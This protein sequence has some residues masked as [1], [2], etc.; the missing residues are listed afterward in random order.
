[1]TPGATAARVPTRSESPSAEPTALLESPPDIPRAWRDGYV[2]RRILVRRLSDARHASVAAIVAPPG[3]GKSSLISE[4][5]RHD[6][7]PFIWPAM[8]GLAATD[9]N[10]AASAILTTLEQAGWSDGLAGSRG[11]HSP[12]RDPMGGLLAA[13]RTLRAR[14]QAF[15]LVL[16]DAHRLAHAVL[17]ELARVMVHEAPSGATLALASRSEL[18]IPLGRLRASRTL[19][20]VRTPELA[21]IPRDALVLLR[22]AGLELEVGAVRKLV[23]L[24]EGWPVGLYL[25]A[26]WVNEQEDPSGAVQLLRGDHHLFDEYFRDEVLSTLSDEMREFATRTSVLKEL[27]GPICDEVLG[28]RGSGLTLRALERATPLLRP[29]DPAHERCRWHSMLRDVLQAELRR[30]EPELVQTLNER[31]SAWY[32]AAGDL[33][34]AIA[35]A[36]AAHDPVRAGSLLWPR[37]LDYLS[38]GR[39]ELVQSWLATFSDDEV[40]GHA[41]LALCAAYSSLIAGDAAHSR[42]WAVAAAALDRPD[43]RAAS[44][45]SSGLTGLEALLPG[46][47]VTAVGAA[48]AAALAL[49]SPASPWC[50]LWL[51]LR[52]TALHLIGDLDAAEQGLDESLDLAAAGAPAVVSLCL[53]QG[54]MIAIERRDWDTAAEHADRAADTIERHGLS[55]EPISALGFAAVAAVRAHQGRLDEAKRDLRHAV[56][57]LAALGDFAGWYGAEARILLAHASLSLADVVRARTLLAEASRLAR[58]V[59]GAVIFD[60]WFNDAWS[61]MD[62]L[63]ETSLAGPSSLTIAELRV[64]R[65]LPSHRSLREI[66]TQLGVSGNTV[67]T[68]AH[69][70]YR[71]LGAASRSEAVASARAAGLLGQ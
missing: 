63:A 62:A 18:P 52:A 25:G 42:R 32:E 14:G 61:Q 67:K 40:C 69:A 1:M 53:A 11:K 70:V 39:N 19:V 26:L 44:Q 30:T 38:Q 33:E 15:V 36:V 65:F 41:P 7:R 3:Y 4:W 45:L 50:P 57:L 24:T 34:R 29:L 28:R 12:R 9:L 48:A 2:R 27:A 37:L 21:M 51:F 55:G 6:A 8:D 43:S 66:A 49:E 64:L 60:R 46:S 13:L 10:R 58:R 23:S 22:Q 5:A 16:D 35:H 54:A 68:Q 56:D 17:R 31:A 59:T 20:E 71:K 47:G